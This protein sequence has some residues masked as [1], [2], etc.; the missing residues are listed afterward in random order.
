M[1]GFATHE[2]QSN[3][4]IAL[5]A[6]HP[7]STQSSKSIRKRPFSSSCYNSASPFLRSI[8]DSLVSLVSSTAKAIMLKGPANS[9]RRP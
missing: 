6:Q 8:L 2:M 7:H 5:Q 1:K 9:L 3:E 4:A